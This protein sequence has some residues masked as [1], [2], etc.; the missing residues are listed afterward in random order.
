MS[1][2]ISI[3]REILELSF[4]DNTIENRPSMTSDTS[5]DKGI[6]EF[7]LES[8]LKPLLALSVGVAAEI[9]EA[10]TRVSTRVN[11]YSA[12]P[13]VKA[14]YHMQKPC[15]AATPHSPRVSPHVWKTPVSKTWSLHVI[16]MQSH[17]APP[18]VSP[19]GTRVPVHLRSTRESPRHLPHVHPH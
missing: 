8:N 5:I 13:A 9:F 4:E 3:D 17:A 16:C 10:P 15:S 11:T 6:L 1:S 7:S 14:V 19:H 12:P 18:N 2:D